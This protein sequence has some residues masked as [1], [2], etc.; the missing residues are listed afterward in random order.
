MGKFTTIAHNVRI[1]KSPTQLSLTKVYRE[2]H[3]F[4]G[5]ES[6]FVFSRFVPFAACIE[7]SSFVCSSLILGFF[8][9]AVVIS[10][11]LAP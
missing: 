11:L 6:D 3:N 5:R 10:F 4:E 7:V 1:I 9:F 2:P 8:L